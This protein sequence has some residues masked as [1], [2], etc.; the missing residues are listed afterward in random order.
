MS[1]TNGL[2]AYFARSADAHPDEPA[3]EVRGT[4]LTYGEL[5][6]CAERLADRL[7]TAA[8]GTPPRRV[9]LLA[10]RSL[11]AYAGYLAILR[12][13]AAVVPLNPEHPA[14][15]VAGIAE[16][17]GLDL[18]LAESADTGDLGVPVLACPP[19]EVP[20]TAED[21]A[22]PAQDR[23]A[24]LRPVSED[25][26]AYIIFT[27]G[28]TGAPKG[29]P[30]RHGNI[31]AYLDRIAG[32]YG[33]GPGSRLSQSFELT[34]DGSVHDLF[35]AWS[36]GG[37]LVVPDRG[38]LLSPVRTVN[39][40]RLTHWFSVP[41]LIGFASR[42]GT[43]TPGSMPTLRWSIFGGEPLTLQ[44]A[45]DWQAAAPGSRIEV[46]YGPTELTIS[47]TSYRFPK[48]PAAWPD[49]PNGTAPIGT[50]HP[51]VDV[52]LLDDAGRPG[53]TGELCVRG[54][55]RFAGYLDPAQDA[56]RFLT[57]DHRPADSPPGPEDWY[58]TG[59]RVALLDG[60]MVHLGRTDHQVKIRGH[61]IELGEIEAALRAL[62]GV[63]EAIAVTVP[64]ADGEPELQAAV[65]GTGTA[66]TLYTALADRLPSYMMPARITVLDQ[67]PLNP[68]GKLDRRALL[69]QLERTR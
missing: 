36:R 6:A 64:A 65:S 12:A 60:L 3:L 7:V 47:C 21:S 63:R 23:T 33:I 56:G 31:C 42:L 16:A 50:A 40:L 37:T 61:R 10:A 39:K 58:R 69:A 62:P 45:R 44:A 4:T 54:P 26:V 34:F 43:L 51:D 14:G 18:V 25:D 68:N 27:S 49:T 24:P 19:E 59:D 46:L 11:T 8:G 30:V 35:V 55:L 41:S 28:S 67:L 17:A 32:R 2:Y 20:V 52:V 5:R 53:D 48:D 1:S 15:R 38:Q 57:E 66:E 13:G 22:A 9:G 29:V